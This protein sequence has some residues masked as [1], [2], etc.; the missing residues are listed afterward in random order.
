MENNKNLEMAIASR[1]RGGPKFGLI[2]LPKHYYIPF[3]DLRVLRRTRAQW[4]RRS[5]MIGVDMDPDRQVRYLHETVKRFEPEYR[6]NSAYR[7]G[8]EGAFGP[9]YGYVE[10]QAL[11]GVIRAVKP[12]RIIEIGSGVPTY[13]ILEAIR[14]NGGSS[15]P[16]SLVSN[17]IRA[18][19]CARRQ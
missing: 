6:G 5:A 7:Q 8:V 1:L 9:G 10:A 2:I 12:C 3:P 18:P 14:K 19:A 16:S 4:A 17:P 13:C 11:H 15:T